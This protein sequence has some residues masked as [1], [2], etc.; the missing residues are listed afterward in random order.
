MKMV[1]VKIRKIRRK[2]L[3]SEH[4]LNKTADRY[5]KRDTATQVFSFEFYKN[6]RTPFYTASPYYCF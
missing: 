4:L 1:L 6:F 2:T 3:V 5:S